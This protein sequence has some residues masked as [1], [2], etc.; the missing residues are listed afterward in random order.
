MGV[1]FRRLAPAASPYSHAAPFPLRRPVPNP[2]VLA[3]Y[4]RMPPTPNEALRYLCDGCGATLVLPASRA[5]AS[6]PCPKCS[7]WIDTSKFVL[8]EIPARVTVPMIPSASNPHVKKRMQ[9]PNRGRGRIRADEFLDHEYNERKEL[10]GT[11]RVLAVFLAV[12]AV[13]LFVT[14]YLRD[15]MMK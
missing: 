10:F 2:S 8:P 14:L 5:G 13:I 6:G 11:M 9:A 15:W 4:I 1:G 7:K 12:A 3:E